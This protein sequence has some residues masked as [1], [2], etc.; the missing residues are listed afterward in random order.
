MIQP[1]AKCVVNGPK[2]NEVIGVI[3]NILKVA[4]SEEFDVVD[5]NNQPGKRWLITGK[6]TG[7]DQQSSGKNRDQL[8]TGPAASA[9]ANNR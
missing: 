9:A 5:P 6:L 2:V 1:N 4:I 7:Q 3:N 8:L